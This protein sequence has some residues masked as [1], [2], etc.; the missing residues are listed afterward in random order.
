MQMQKQM[1][2]STK[3]CT[4]LSQNTRSLENIYSLLLY[5]S[6]RAK[7]ARGT[8]AVLTGDHI[9]AR[10]SEKNIRKE[11]QPMSEQDTEDRPR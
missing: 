2:I 9:R 7:E 6:R 8:W 1:Q 5:E 11:S 3:Y 10:K 4:T